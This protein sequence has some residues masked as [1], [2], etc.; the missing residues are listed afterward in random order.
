[1]SQQ[2]GVAM[3]SMDTMAIAQSMD[4]FEQ[5]MEGLDAQSTLIQNAMPHSAVDMPIDQVDALL[6]QVCE[7]HGMNIAEKLP[8]LPTVRSNCSS[9]L[10]S[11]RSH[12]LYRPFLFLSVSRPRI[13]MSLSSHCPRRR[14]P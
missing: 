14:I 11:K 8:D 13:C 10:P 2:L 4:Q 9:T 7:E 1:M 5:Q 3:Q 12:Q 6:G